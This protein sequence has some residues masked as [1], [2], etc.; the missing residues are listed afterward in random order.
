MDAAKQF[1]ARGGWTVQVVE[2]EATAVAEA[3]RIFAPTQ[4]GLEPFHRGWVNTDHRL[5]PVV[6]CE[7]GWEHA[8]SDAYDLD[9]DARI[10]MDVLR[11]VVGLQARVWGM[12]PEE[13]VPVNLLAILPD[14]GGGTLVAYQRDVGFNAD[15]WLG[16]IIGAG[17]VTGTYVSHMLGVNPDVRGDHDIG[18]QLKVLQAHRALMTGH[19]QMQWTFDPMRGANARLNLEKLGATV[20]EFTI[21]K[22]GSLFSDLYGDVSS[23]RFTANWDLCDRATRA[24]VEAVAAG[25]YRPLEPDD[26]AECPE[27]TKATVDALVA[28]G[29]PR[30]RYRI[31]GDIDRLMGDDPVAALHWRGEM[32][33]CVSKLLTTKSGIVDPGTHEGPAAMNTRTVAGPYQIVGFATGFDRAGERIS[34]YL[35]ERRRGE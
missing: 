30:L 17:S 11:F 29:A 25:N 22:Y 35:L 32:R 1:V 13:L 16:F 24:R 19:S 31:P 27:A 14:T 3:R 9:G 23:D 21:D 33:D 10:P 8:G 20:A 26:I 28:A 12:P 2:G 7:L 6:F 18:W 5:G 34:D 15:G 4:F